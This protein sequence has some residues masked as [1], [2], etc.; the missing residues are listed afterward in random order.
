MNW[1]ERHEETA[2][3]LVESRGV[4]GD[5]TD[6]AWVEKTPVEVPLRMAPKNKQV[7][8]R[9]R[10]RNVTMLSHGPCYAPCPPVSSKFKDQY[11][12]LVEGA[13]ELQGVWGCPF[14]WSKGKQDEGGRGCPASAVGSPWRLFKCG[15]GTC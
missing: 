11:R 12:G 3:V 4:W 7:A 15:R 6:A 5:Q 1:D 9:K 2:W 14:Q 8:T 10:G 13:R